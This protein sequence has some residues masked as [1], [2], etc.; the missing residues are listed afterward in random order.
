MKKSE[1]AA[2]KA[3]CLEAGCLYINLTG[4]LMF[5]GVWTDSQ[6]RIGWKKKERGGKE[7]GGVCKSWGA[8]QVLYE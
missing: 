3:S 6:V 7:G 5:G 8:G 1:R 2:E 4:R